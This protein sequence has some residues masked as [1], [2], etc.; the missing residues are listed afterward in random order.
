MAEKDVATTVDEKDYEH[1]LTWRGWLSFIVI[2]LSFSG[3]LKDMGPLSAFDFTVLTGKFGKIEGLSFI[4]KGG[5]G[6]AEGFMFALTLFPTVILALGFV[7]VVESRGGLLAAERIIRPLLRPLMGLPGYVGLA[8]ISSFTTT[9]VGAVI[10]RDL[11]DEGKLTDD[12]RTIF[13][14]YQYAASGTLANT[15]NCG[16][17]LMPIS[18]LSFGIIFMVEIIVKIIGANII[19]VYLAMK[20]KKA[21]GGAN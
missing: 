4:G 19:R 2:A 16:A 20:R 18:L 13:V 5:V 12:E 8:F 15:I 1:H 6:A 17:P 10:T 7:R 3:I 14:A 11:Y 21:V 9:D